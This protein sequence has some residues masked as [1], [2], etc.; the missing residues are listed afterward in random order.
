MTALIPIR[1]KKRIMKT[2]TVKK[3]QSNFRP[4]EPIWPIF[5][6]RGFEVEFEF[7]PGGWSSPA[8][9]TVDGVL[10]ADRGDY[11]KLAGLTNFFSGNGSNTAF[12]G[13]FPGDEPETWVV[14][15][16]VNYPGSAF[17]F[18]QKNTIV[19]RSGDTG[20]IVCAFSGGKARYKL[21]A[22]STVKE[23]SFDFR[24][25]RIMRQAGTFAGGSNNSPGPYG[26]VAI[27][28]MAVRIGFK[29]TR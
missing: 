29:V 14:G 10:D 22:G 13:F 17:K 4:Y 12:T 26:G 15:A 1:A 25:S 16:Y 8:E 2:Y 27:K 9:W 3:G 6:A 5:G 18:D 19:V 7:V 11:Q 28:D 21:I 23:T 20:A 24:K